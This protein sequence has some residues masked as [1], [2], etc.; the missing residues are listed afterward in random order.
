MNTL[1]TYSTCRMSTTHF[2]LLPIV[3]L[4]DIDDIL[5]LRTS[6]SSSYSLIGLAVLVVLDLIVLV[7]SG[8]DSVAKEL[9]LVQ[10]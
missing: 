2:G 5:I 4:G 9:I 10:Y 6:C 1:N 7:R 3:K 8:W